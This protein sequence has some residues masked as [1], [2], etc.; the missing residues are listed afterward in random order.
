M[1]P[2]Y[3]AALDADARLTEACKLAYPGKRPGDTR[4]WEATDPRVIKA[5]ADK[6]QADKAW[7]QYMAENPE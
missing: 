6:V 1:N 3:N 7:L 2:L 4:Y 5:K